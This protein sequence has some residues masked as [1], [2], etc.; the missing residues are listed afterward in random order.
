MKEE[1]MIEVLKAYFGG[2]KVEYRP[3]SS[4][5]SHVWA[6]VNA[7]TSWN[8]N[9]CDYRA[10]PGHVFYDEDVEQVTVEYDLKGNKLL[11]VESSAVTTEFSKEDLEYMLTV[12]EEKT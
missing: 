9:H 10:K 4:I 7:N 5:N 8:W 3:K 11:I 6:P 12:L 1:A 2:G